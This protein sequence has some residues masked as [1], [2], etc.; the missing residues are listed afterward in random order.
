MANSDTI[1]DLSD[2][3]MA[4]AKPQWQP[5]QRFLDAEIAASVRRA[6]E[7]LGESWRFIGRVI[8]VSHSHLILIS[9]GK[10]VPSVVVVEAMSGMPFAPGEYERL[11]KA[12]VKGKGR[13][14]PA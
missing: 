3:S 9:Q 11:H 14:R 1:R 10:R 6:K 12:A 5:P 4:T 2:D 13:D 7:R 8:G